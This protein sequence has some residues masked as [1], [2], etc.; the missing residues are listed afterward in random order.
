MSRYGPHL[1]SDDLEVVA[2]IVGVES[3]A[4]VV[5]DHVVVP[6]APLVAIGVVPE[7]L[8]CSNK[9]CTGAK[10]NKDTEWAW[11]W[12]RSPRYKRPART[13]NRCRRD[14]AQQVL[15]CTSYAQ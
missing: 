2:V 10:L 15:Y 4:V 11:P 14:G 7:P 13:C 12:M 5:V 3:V 1:V 6:L 9:Q 8:C